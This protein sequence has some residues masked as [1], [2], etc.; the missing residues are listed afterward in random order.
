MDLW[1]SARSEFHVKI[2]TWLLGWRRGWIGAE[3]GSRQ[4]GD[5]ERG[6]ATDGQA[7]PQVSGPGDGEGREFERQV[8]EQISKTLEERE[9]RTFILWSQ[10]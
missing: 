5:L 4:E 2:S 3:G 10:I 6:L 8:K 9:I 7:L 1:R